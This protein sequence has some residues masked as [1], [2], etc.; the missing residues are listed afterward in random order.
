MSA[1]SSSILG[2]IL[3]GGL[4]RRMEG[5]EKS[6]LKLD[7]ETL[8]SR[9]ANR[10]EKQ[11]GKVIL[12]ANG[13]P[14]RFSTLGLEI[15]A[16]TV[17]GF[18]GPLAGVLAGM[19]WAKESSNATH[20][21]TAAADTPFFPKSYSEDMLSKA[22]ETNSHIALAGSNGRKHPVFGLW[23]ISLT[24]ALEDFLVKENNRKVMLFVERYS[25]IIVEF[26]NHNQGHDPFFNVNTPDD[27]K[28]AEEISRKLKT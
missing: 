23:P 11:T 9:V 25:N 19:R 20:I 17:E 26:K 6:L 14:A 22:K 13:D 21:I 15:Q 27:M 2:V 18:A 12:N 4:S 7:G 8:V 24:N 16:D 10:L 3:A 1:Q 5:P 28:Q